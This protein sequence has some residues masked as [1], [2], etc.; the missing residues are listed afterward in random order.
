MSMSQ[1]L[2]AVA[3]G[4][5]TQV[6]PA[7]QSRVAGDVLDNS[8][9][10]LTAIANALDPEEPAGIS[11]PVPLGA[12][13]DTDRLN[14]PAENLAANRSTGTSIAAVAGT[15]DGDCDMLDAS[16]A[17]VAWE[18]S[19]L[20][21]GVARYDAVERAPFSTVD[22]QS[23]GID[24]ERLL[25]YLRAQSGEPGVEIAGFRP[26]LGGRSRQTVLFEIANSAKL[27]A[28]L[29][30]QRGLPGGGGGA[31]FVAIDAQYDLLATLHNAG[32]RVPRPVLFEA[33]EEALGASFLI[34]EQS[35]GVPAES[36]YWR[37]VA[38]PEVA[39]DLARE[40]ALLHRQPLGSLGAR[41]PQS[42]ERY[43]RAGWSDELEYQAGTWFREAHWPSI[44]M[45]AAIAWMRANI[46]CLEDM[47][48]FVHNDMMFHNILAE[49]GRITAVLDWEQ[50]SVGH[51]G[52]DLGYV[53]PVVTAVT[54]WDSFLDAYRAAGGAPVS[55]R[56]IDYFA[57]RAGVR[58]MN[59]VML[60]GRNAFEQGLSNEV[61]VASA[62]AHF[63]Q[64]LMHR[65]AGVVESV[66][67]RN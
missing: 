54:D 60:G 16:R 15:L 33:G 41:L 55:Q 26:I 32:M 39:M 52:E 43:D 25:A 63:T 20:D 65:I 49:N 28:K 38:Q 12:P 37:P 10:V 62:G 6:H 7:V 40:M 27:P 19:L 45:S 30:V 8:I 48:S 29:V 42:R 57:L 67:A 14:G 47:R 56:Q 35:P 58:L 3:R 4:L 64:R 22:D 50:C 5:R 23:S 34:T 21:A 61:L 11:A 2:W 17:A 13:A 59:L 44:T 36:D 31:A 18:K 53:Y 46:D 9:R 24:R 1:Y 66:L 51:P